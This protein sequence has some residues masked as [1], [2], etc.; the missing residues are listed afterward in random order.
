MQ[1]VMR[2][3]P[4]N[5]RR[6]RP[7]DGSPSFVRLEHFVSVLDGFPDVKALHLQG[8]GEPMMHPRFFDMLHH[9]VCKGITVSCNS[10]LRLVAS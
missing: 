9:A 3:V 6:D 7:S 1:S 5:L 10:N 8:L 4:V 2:H